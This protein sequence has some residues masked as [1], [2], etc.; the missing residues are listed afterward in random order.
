Y[1]ISDRESCLAVF[2]SNVPDGFFDASE[3]AGFAAFRNGPQCPYFVMEH[4]GA[5]V[6]CGGFFTDPE[7]IEASLTWGMIRRDAQKPSLGRFLLLYR[8]REISKIGTVQKVRMS[9]SQR[10]AGFFEK[11]GLKTVQVT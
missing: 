6:G 11:Q 1:S 3:R 5:I 2:D 7:R 4:D 9:T 8:I 10:A